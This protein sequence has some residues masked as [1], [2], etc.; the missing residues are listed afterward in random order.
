MGCRHSHCIP[1]ADWGGGSDDGYERL[2][3]KVTG[4]GPRGARKELELLVRRMI[5]YYE[6]EPLL[7]LQGSQTG[8]D[9]GFSIT[10]NPSVTFDGGDKMVAFGLTNETD[11]TVV[12]SVIDKKDAVIIA[13]KGDDYEVYASDHQPD[14]LETAD[15]ARATM[16]DLQ[17]DAVVR[18]R[19]FTS[20]PAGNAGTDATPEFTFVNGDA[21]LS[22][23]GAGLLVVS[24][25]LTLKKN[26]SFKGLNITGGDSKIEGSV[27]LA[28]YNAIGNFLA[29]TV[30][31]KGGNVE[32]KANADRV[33][34]ALD[35]VNMRVLA[36]REN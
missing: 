27:I 17:A 33:L 22:G 8:G 18:S 23:S 14:F 29:S 9:V 6:P 10:G 4:Y 20:Y 21:E 2:I 11:Q 24:G 12:Q 30:N 1:P 28:R 5:F 13:G 31:V 34:A 25:S 32:F 35:T 26:S 16:S 19:H 7:Y 36:V 15:R 3:V